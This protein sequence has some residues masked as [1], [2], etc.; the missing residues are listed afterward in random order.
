[1][2]GLAVHFGNQQPAS[3]CRL[4]MFAAKTNV[5][6]DARFRRFGSRW[7]CRDQQEAADQTADREEPRRLVRFIVHGE[8]QVFM[9]VVIWIARPS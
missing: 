5:S 7:F 9:L 8:Y 4:Q 3:F 1:V 2:A 6:G